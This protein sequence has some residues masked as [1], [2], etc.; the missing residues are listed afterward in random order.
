MER[1][2]YEWP[3]AGTRVCETGHTTASNKGPQIHANRLIRP[4]HSHLEHDKLTAYNDK[5]LVVRS[6]VQGAMSKYNI[7][8]TADACKQLVRAGIVLHV[9]AIT[10]GVVLERVCP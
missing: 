3:D 2:W 10:A 6:D 9:E 7:T 5:Q 1:T 8:F 4:L